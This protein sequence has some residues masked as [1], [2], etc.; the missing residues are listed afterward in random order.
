MIV[1]WKKTKTRTRTRTRPRTRTKYENK[2]KTMKFDHKII[3]IKEITVFVRLRYFKFQDAK[4]ILPVISI[5]LKE[6]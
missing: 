2:T 3:A 1:A 6:W 4:N 5:K